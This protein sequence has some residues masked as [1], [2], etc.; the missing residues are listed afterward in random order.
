[1]LP[2]I[3]DTLLESITLLANAARLLADRAIAGFRVRT[4]RIARHLATNPILV[5]ALNP[6]IGYARAAEIA[7][8][9]YLEDRPIVDVA[10]EL[11]DIPRAELERLLDPARLAGID[12]RR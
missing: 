5:T 2:V 7:K 8:R 3:A 10:E 11:T 4:S 6:L 1:M 12:Q 9:A